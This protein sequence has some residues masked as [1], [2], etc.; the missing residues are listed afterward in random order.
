MNGRINYN[1][2]SCGVLFFFFLLFLFC[3]FFGGKAQAKNLA[4]N[5]TTTYGEEKKKA[6][7]RQDNKIKSIPPQ[8]EGLLFGKVGKGGEEHQEWQEW[9][10]ATEAQLSLREAVVWSLERGLPG[11][12]TWLAERLWA[13]GRTQGALGLLATCHLRA[14]RAGR[15]YAL[16]CPHLPPPPAGDAAGR[17]GPAAAAP[18]SLSEPNRFLFAQVCFQLGRLKEAHDVLLPHPTATPPMGAAGFYLLGQVLR[19]ALLSLCLLPAHN[20][21]PGYPRARAVDHR[22]GGL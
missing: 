18:G 3:L 22:G 19:C 12:A 16:L 10:G 14:G 8:M 20:I 17:T 11:N 21:R 4:G 15:A 13:M 9:L 1:L 6:C 2:Y 5:N 7:L